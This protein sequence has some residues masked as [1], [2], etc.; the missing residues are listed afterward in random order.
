M[1]RLLA[2]FAV[3]VAVAAAAITSSDS[4][5]AEAR[6]RLDF[7]PGEFSYVVVGPNNGTGR[8]Q[9]FLPYTV[10]NDSEG[11]RAPGL[12]LEVRTET[13][14]TFGDHFGA[15]A[16]KAI[17]KDLKKKKVSSTFQLRSKKLAK[18]DSAEGSAHFGRMDDNADELEVRVYGLWNP[19][20]NDKKGKRWR[21]NRVL[22]LK[23]RRYG[24]EYR[25]YE[26]KI[27]LV[28]RSTEVEGTR[29]Q[30]KHPAE[31]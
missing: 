17:A 29:S 12:R 27:S 2:V 25:R 10:K 15:R 20:Y 19:V 8:V 24:D 22:V 26:D 3:V 7:E 11:E 31:K 1:K 23:Y 6:W 5:S 16:Y 4:A 18:G 13:K 28:S 21:E 30:L 9:Y 14:K